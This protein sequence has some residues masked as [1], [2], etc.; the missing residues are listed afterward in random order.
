MSGFLSDGKNQNSKKYHKNTT[1]RVHKKKNPRKN[2]KNSYYEKSMISS[3]IPE[4]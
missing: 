1:T 3:E 4:V 2:S